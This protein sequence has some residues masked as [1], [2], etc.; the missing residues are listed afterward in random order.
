MDEYISDLDCN[1][2]TPPK[3]GIQWDG[4]F[5]PHWEWFN[6]EVE[7]DQAVANH[8]KEQC[9]QNERMVE[10]LRDHLDDINAEKILSYEMGEMEVRPW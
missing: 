6:T 2:D 10:E 8:M 1:C 3:Y 5:G 7:R 4:P 9:E